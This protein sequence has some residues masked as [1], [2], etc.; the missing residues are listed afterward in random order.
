MS[1]LR[2]DLDESTVR[3]LSLIK[4]RLEATGLPSTTATSV[5]VALRRTAKELRD[6]ESALLA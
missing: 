6:C 1:E 4:Q 3:D 5:R 2:M